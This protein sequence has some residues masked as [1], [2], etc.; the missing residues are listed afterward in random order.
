MEAFV[1]AFDLFVNPLGSLG[2]G[3]TDDFSNAA[4]TA[5]AKLDLTRV[6]LELEVR[7]G[8]CTADAYDARIRPTQFHM[9]VDALSEM[10]ESQVSESIVCRYVESGV[11]TSHDLGGRPLWMRRKIAVYNADVEMQACAWDLRIA[12]SLEV[13][14]KRSPNPKMALDTL[15]RTRRSFVFGSWRLD[16][17]S[18]IS[19]DSSKELCS[20][21]FELLQRTHHDARILFEELLALVCRLQS[22]VEEGPI[23]GVAPSRVV[24]ESTFGSA[25]R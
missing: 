22:I 10:A 9:I 6:P 14:L 20:F 11:S 21:E 25:Q 16:A 1:R 23:K 13:P 18:D 19:C 3:S 15:A 2:T 24:R 4:A 7:L 17:T 8:M 12:L 5:L